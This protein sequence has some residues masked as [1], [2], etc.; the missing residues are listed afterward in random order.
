MPPLHLER[1]V[2]KYGNVKAVDD[3]SPRQ[4]TSDPSRTFGVWED[5]H[6]EVCIRVRQ[7]RQW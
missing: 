7:T 4:G 6:P 1:I 2:K 3:L 5:D